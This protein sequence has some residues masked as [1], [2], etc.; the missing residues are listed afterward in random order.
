MKKTPYFRY[1]GPISGLVA[2][3]RARAEAAEAQALLALVALL[4]LSRLTY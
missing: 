2:A 4:I 1:C 3:A